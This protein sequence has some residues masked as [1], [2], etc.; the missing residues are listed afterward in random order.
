MRVWSDVLLNF[1]FVER[2]EMKMS[3]LYVELPHP[4][5]FYRSNNSTNSENFG[6]FCVNDLY[7]FWHQ[8]SSFSLLLSWEACK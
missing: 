8:S 1:K 5:I 6:F 3:V 7:G 4:V 2:K